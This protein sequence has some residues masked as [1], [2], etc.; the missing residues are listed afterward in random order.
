MSNW[1]NS[2]SGKLGGAV[3]SS[4]S[5]IIDNANGTIRIKEGDS[6]GIDVYTQYGNG[7]NHYNIPIAATDSE[8][9]PIKYY[10]K[11]HMNQNISGSLG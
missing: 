2:A 4:D 10:I 7:G 6:S 1:A 3:N 11:M 8:G 5:M 9:K